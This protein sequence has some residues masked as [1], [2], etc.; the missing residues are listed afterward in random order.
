MSASTRT[1]SGMAN[2][3]PRRR[4]E[5]ST[6]SRS[7]WIAGGPVTSA[8]GPPPRAS[9]ARSRA[10]QR[11]RLLQPER[12]RDLAVDR[13]GSD[14]ERRQPPAGQDVRGALETGAQLTLEPPVGGVPNAE[15]HGE[16]PVGPL[17]EAARESRVRAR[18]AG[19]G[20]LVRVR[21][22]PGKRDRRRD[23]DSERGEPD[24]EDVPAMAEN[25]QRPPLEE[26]WT[27]FGVHDGPYLTTSIASRMAGS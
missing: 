5:D 23:S 9:A 12:R 3:S 14:P 10:G 26:R 22:A 13:P 19:P 8:A 18:G 4:S 24:R 1:A 16:R 11:L 17:P 2:A 6:G 20:D 15:D 7:C 25:E 27:L 21:E